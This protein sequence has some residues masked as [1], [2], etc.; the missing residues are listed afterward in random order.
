MVA[1]ETD[2]P[3]DFL[4]LV[5]RLRTT[6]S[7]SYTLRDTP[8]LHLHLVLGRAGPRCARR[9]A[10][11]VSLSERADS[12]ARAAARRAPA[13]SR[14]GAA[15]PVI[16]P[17]RRG[18]ETGSATP[19]APAAPTR[20][21]RRAGALDRRPAALDQGGAG[22]LRAAARPLRRADADA[23]GGARPTTR[24]SCARRPACRAPRSVPALAGRARAR[25]L[26]GA[27]A[28]RR[29]ARRRGDRRADRGQGDRA[30]ERPHVPDVPPRRP[31]VLAV[32][33]PRHPPRGH[34][35]LRAAGACP[36]PAEIER[37]AEPWRPTGRWPAVYLWR[38]LDATPV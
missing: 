2:N 30:V 21:L 25:R 36:T 31:D 35:P 9:R 20:P 27:R 6:E 1:F 23:R 15:E 24:R 28:A 19:H 14:S 11:P 29:P 5:Q 12:M 22:D 37:S 34:A 4:D 8:T 7:S 17:R 3:A 33:R 16:D 10:L 13:R 32:G 18:V 38:S 26:A